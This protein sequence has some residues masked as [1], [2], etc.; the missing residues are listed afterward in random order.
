VE[1]QTLTVENWRKSPRKDVRL[2]KYGS[3]IEKA[4]DGEIRV[5]IS[6]AAR[7]RD[8][9]TLAPEGWDL[10]NYKKNPVVL[11]AHDHHTPPIAQAPRTFVSDGKLISFPEFVDEEIYPFGAMIGKMVNGGWLKAASVGFNPK[12]WVFN[13]EEQGYDFDS[14]ELLEFSIVCVG[15]NPEALVGAKSAGIN[16]APMATWAEKTLDMKR[17]PDPSWERTDIERV[18]QIAR[19]ERVITSGGKIDDRALLSVINRVIAKN[20]K[21]RKSKPDPLADLEKRIQ[22]ATQR[23]VTRLTGR[24]F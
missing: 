16:L 14:Q 4:A 18:Y 20:I 19:G 12:T 23:V 6:T 2:V 10:S 24:V 21:P 3:E 11:W 7:D 9:D 17:Q 13:E 5:V 8:K 1:L 22:T 15:S